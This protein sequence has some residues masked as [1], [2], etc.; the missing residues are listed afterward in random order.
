MSVPFQYCRAIP[1]VHGLYICGLYT[2]GL[3]SHSPYRRAPP[4]VHAMEY[5]MEHTIERTVKHTIEHAIEHTI[6]CTNGHTIQHT[7]E[8]TSVLYL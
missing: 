3:C 6:K 1:I 7:I 2:Y 4:I 5:A 8:H